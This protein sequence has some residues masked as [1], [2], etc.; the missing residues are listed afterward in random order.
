MIR[1][2]ASPLLL[3]LGLSGAALTWAM[4]TDAQVATSW[5]RAT[6]E[7]A[8]RRA[9]SLLARGDTFAAASAY[10]EAIRVDPSFG[11]PYLSLSEIRRAL[12]DLRETEWLLTQAARL[13]EVR[14]EALSR[15]ARFYRATGRA[16]SALL[17]W[18]AAADA[19]PT[20]PRLRELATAYIERRAWSAAL[21]TYRR[22]RVVSKRD[23]GSPVDREIDDTVQ[24]LG[25]L[26]AETDAAQHDTGEANWIR[27]S[28]RHQARR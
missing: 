21:S 19:E 6:A 7:S 9:E 2:A 14:A 18:E 1:R 17:D 28:L 11:A 16:A 22:L 15:R 4:P 10:T 8:F 3:G 26:A 23:V 12:G 25:V 20:E 27:S 5:S 24:A 13:Q